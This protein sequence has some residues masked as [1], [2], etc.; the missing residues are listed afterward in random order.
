[1]NGFE[2]FRSAITDESDTIRVAAFGELD[3]GSVE[4]L[5]KILGRCL[6]VPGVRRVMVDMS[7]VTFCDCSGLRT[8]MEAR[9]TALRRRISFELT[10]VKASIV[11]RLLPITGTD[12]LFGLNPSA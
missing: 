8:L 6:Q 10:D 4:D 3:L 5:Q 12:A 11:M 2:R 9:E 1:M 7:Q